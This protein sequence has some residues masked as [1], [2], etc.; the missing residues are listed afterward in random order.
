M[1]WEEV[2]RLHQGARELFK[3]NASAVPRET[4]SKA[5]EDQWSPAH[6]T[7]HVVLVYKVMLD[8]LNGGKGMVIRTG[9]V[10]RNFLRLFMVPGLLHG[11]PFPKGA[12]AP[13]ETRP[14]RINEN[15]IDAVVEF[16]KLSLQFENAAR[17]AYERNRQTQL[18]HA[19][20]G[21]ADLVKSMQLCARHVL[22]HANMMTHLKA[23]AR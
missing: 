18:T 2:L 9:F 7:E 19:Y 23:T 14:A 15:Q 16:E 6:I 22:H 8:E 5:A 11:K 4:W 17:K 12:R 3:E 13:R 21:R 20:F 1:N 10:R